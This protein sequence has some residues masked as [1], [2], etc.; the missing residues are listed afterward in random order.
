MKDEILPQDFFNLGR[1]M[2][3][4]GKAKTVGFG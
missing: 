4:I 2:R 3:T 1:R